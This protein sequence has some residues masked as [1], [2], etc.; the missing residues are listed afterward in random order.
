MGRHFTAP[1]PVLESPRR[2]HRSH[3]LPG[4]STARRRQWRRWADHT[5]GSFPPGS[6]P[7]GSWRVRPRLLRDLPSRGTLPRRGMRRRFARAFRDP[8][9]AISGASPGSRR[10]RLLPLAKLYRRH[11]SRGNLRR[12]GTALELRRALLETPGLPSLE[13]GPAGRHSERVG[14]ASGF[15]F[16]AP[17]PC[18]AGTS[19]AAQ[20]RGVGVPRLEASRECRGVYRMILWRRRHHHGAR[21]IVRTANPTSS[22]IRLARAGNTWR[23]GS[24]TRTAAV[25][26]RRVL[27]R[28]G[29]SALSLHPDF[30]SLPYRTLDRASPLKG[31][32]Q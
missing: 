25:R 16:P 2:N 27:F 14:S 29:R 15:L 4:W 23:P 19:R 11:G 31:D 6:T 32:R 13:L 28:S 17:P 10:I 8:S 18:A 26:G 9:L 12:A 7:S 3:I 1:S 30:D 22:S 5:V 20:A 24:W 21:A